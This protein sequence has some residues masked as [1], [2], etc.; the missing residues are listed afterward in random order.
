MSTDTFWETPLWDP[1]FC[2]EIIET[3]QLQPGKQASVQY[4]GTRSEQKSVRVCTGYGL[5]PHEHPN[6]TNPLIEK[7]AENPWQFKLYADSHILSSVD[8]I[9]YKPGDFF[10][11]H[12]DWGGTTNDRKISV[13]VQ[14]SSPDEYKD[15]S[16]LIYDGPEPWELNKEQGVATFFPSWTLHEVKPLTEGERWAL[17]CFFCGPAFT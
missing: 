8:V 2:Q 16:V 11:T 5:Q 6:I 9:N 3:A 17:V 12:T 7:I 15:G 13:T 4:K 10:T 14:L 1:Q